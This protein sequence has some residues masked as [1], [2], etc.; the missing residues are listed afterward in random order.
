MAINEKIYIGSVDTPT[1]SFNPNNIEDIVC[2]NAVD[3]IGNELSCDTLEVGVAFGWEI[4]C[5]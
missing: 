3:L 5:F 1:L 2:N 4:L